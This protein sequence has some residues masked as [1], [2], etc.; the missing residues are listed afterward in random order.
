MFHV[1]HEADIRS[2]TC[3]EVIR[4][5]VGIGIE[6]SP[7]QARTIARHLALVLEA[8][9]HMNLT[10][11]REPA[12]ALRLH[13]CDSL[14]ALPELLECPEGPC[15]DL[16]SGA[17][18]PGIP[19]AVVSGRRFVLCESIKRKALFLD[20]VVDDLGLGYHVAVDSRRAE[21]LSKTDRERFTCVVARAVAPLSALVELASPLLAEGGRLVALKSRSS[22]EIADADRTAR[23]VGMKYRSTREVLLPGGGELRSLIVYEREGVASVTLPRR[24]GMA[25]K[26]PV[27]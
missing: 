14:L 1:K 12:E 3:S 6:L 20:T 21:D 11:I 4:S 7:D 15:V 2:A 24:T 26:R 10:A 22:D 16:G 19:L 13:V 25:Q 18:F 8:N 27:S 5:A 23:V 17:G 9:E